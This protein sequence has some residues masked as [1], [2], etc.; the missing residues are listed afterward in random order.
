MDLVD[1][2]VSLGLPAKSVVDYRPD[3]VLKVQYYFVTVFVGD[4]EYCSYDFSY[5][6]DY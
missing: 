3:P 2:L 6:D 1:L 4:Y 5:G